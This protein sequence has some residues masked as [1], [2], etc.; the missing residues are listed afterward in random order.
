MNNFFHEK[1]RRINIPNFLICT[2]HP[3]TCCYIAV[4]IPS[5]ATSASTKQ[6]SFTRDPVS[7]S[8]NSLNETNLGQPQ[9][10][11]GVRNQLPSARE[12]RAFPLCYLDLP[13]ILIACKHRHDTY[14]EKIYVLPLLD[15]RFATYTLH[16]L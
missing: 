3:V 10:D 13:Q 15:P 1:A 14:L 2:N 11:S 5:T 4:E 8:L 12:K 9:L 16:I 7:G 6:T